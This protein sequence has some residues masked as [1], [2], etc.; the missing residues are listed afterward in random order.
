MKMIEKNEIETAM[1]IEKKKE[2]SSPTIE[3]IGE[4]RNITRGATIGGTDA[5]G[6]SANVPSDVNW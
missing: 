1:K 2:Y 4:V 3:A 5:G 6:Q